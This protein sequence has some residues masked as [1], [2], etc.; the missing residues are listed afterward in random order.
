[1][2]PRKPGYSIEIYRES[3]ARYAFPDGEAWSTDGRETF[4]DNHRDLIVR[5]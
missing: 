4:V 2:P 5:E 1:M 3:L